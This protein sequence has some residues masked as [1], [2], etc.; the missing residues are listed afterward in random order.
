M[1]TKLVKLL[2]V[3][4]AVLA[5]IIVGEWLYASYAKR[6]MI[7]S[8]KS[9]IIKPYQA[10]ALPRLDLARRTEE[11]YADLA[12]RPLFIK[13][14]RPVDEPDVSKNGGLV[15]SDSFDWQLNGIYSSEKGISALFSHTKTADKKNKSLKITT[16]DEIEGWKLTEIGKDSVILNKDS[17]RKEVMLRKPKLKE[18]PQQ[19]NL[20]NAPKIKAET[21]ENKENE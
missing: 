11:S 13:G 6:Q 18:L 8:I 4:C 19:A 17:N 15:E 2:T 16:G 10:D 12:A 3:V 5:L 14:R 20:A 9:G 21:P 7:L 1:N